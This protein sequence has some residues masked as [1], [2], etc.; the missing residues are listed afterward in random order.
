MQYKKILPPRIK[1]ILRNSKRN[2]DKFWIKSKYFRKLGFANACFVILRLL[3][4]KKNL[5]VFVPAISKKVAIRPRTSDIPTFEK[6]FIIEEYKFDLANTPRFII[7]A[8][9]NVGYAAL[10]FANCYPQAEIICIEPESSNI[11][12]LRE[13]TKDYSQITILSQALWY[14]KTFLQIDNPQD[15]KYAFRVSETQSSKIESITVPEILQYRKWPRVDLF[16]IDIEGAEKSVFSQNTAWIKCIS[17]IVIELHEQMLPGCEKSF[18]SALN[19]YGDYKNFTIGEN[20]VVT[21]SEIKN[22]TY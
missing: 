12:I 11:A 10:F 14:T 8:G 4:S 5:Y 18:Y 15:S 22:W 6:I 7:D 9:A 1:K 3:I 13:N 2:F 21:R 17:T 19:E 16:K 20:T